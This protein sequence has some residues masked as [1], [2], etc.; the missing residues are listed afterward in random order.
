MGLCPAAADSQEGF[1][2]IVLVPIKGSDTRESPLRVAAYEARG[3]G[4]H[5]PEGKI[6]LEER[7]HN[8]EELHGAVPLEQ[9]WRDDTGKTCGN[10]ETYRSR[11]TRYKQLSYK[12]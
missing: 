12:H 11:S 4:H 3:S 7:S 1:V 8:L 5:L 6:V 10:F 9:L 2:V